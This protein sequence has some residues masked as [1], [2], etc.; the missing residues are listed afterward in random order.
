M[1]LIPTLHIEQARVAEA[2]PPDASGDGE[3]T[4]SDQ[5]KRWAAA[6]AAWI[7]IV[8]VEA[9]R[10]GKSHWSLIP[11]ALGRPLRVVFGGG[12]R[13]MTQLQQLLDLGVER[14]AV[15][16]QAVRNPLWAKELGIIFPKKVILALDV[17]GG[18][19][20]V[21]G[22]EDT[23]LDPVA[24]ARGLDDCAFA[25]MTINCWKDGECVL[26]RDLVHTLRKTLKTPLWVGGAASL[27]DLEWLETEGIQAALVGAPGY[28]GRLDVAA[29]IRALP[30]LNPEPL[31]RRRPSPE[32]F[33]DARAQRMGDDSVE[34][35]EDEEA[36]LDEP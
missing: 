33:E 11:Q 1:R 12:V 23:G 24:F 21:A 20:V 13:S 10:G 5:T 32:E 34:F 9:M 30:D 6:G 7:Q 15:G 18:K 26:D 36:A 35:P 27:A 31:P 3:P 8:D 19:L 17:E 25:A 4:V 22:G 16:T 14:V 28:T 2:M 29:A